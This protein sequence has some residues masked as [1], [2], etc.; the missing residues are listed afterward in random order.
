MAGAAVV[1]LATGCLRRLPPPAPPPAR[2]PVAALHA[3]H[4]E[5]ELL[6]VRHR[7]K[8]GQTLYRIAR[9]YGLTTA[10]LMEANGIDDPRTL[11]VGQELVIPGATEALDVPPTEPA[12]M[13][14]PPPVQGSID[15]PRAADEPPPAAGKKKP[16]KV[17]KVRVVMSPPSTPAAPKEDAAVDEG[18]NAP[19]PRP[20]SNPETAF[21]PELPPRFGPELPP[22]LGPRPPPKSS[23]VA[24]ASAPGSGTPPGPVSTSSAAQAGAKPASKA[25]LEW[26]L[27]GV[28]YARF[29]KK[30]KEAHD[31]IDLAAPAGTEVATAA[32]GT[33]LFAGEQ[34]GYGRIAIVEHAHGLITLYAH[35]RDL[36]VK[37][38]QKV[39]AGQ[40]IATVGESGKTSGP[41]LHF[42]V[43][44]E[45][46]PVD[47]LEH[48][49][50]VPPR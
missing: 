20:A 39:R 27:R 37:T 10:E 38:G 5:P 18:S 48:L 24:K 12:A 15:D 50:P 47:P 33:V 41:H 2:S 17:S 34:Q 11:A 36:R 26:P 43:R 40:V 30:G 7:V 25:P 32:E 23:A 42:E 22:E 6:S 35:N 8:P 4:A 16:P 44:K 31:G 49:G 1:L 46:L 21:G 28:L 45:G 19:K 14:P 29:G 3:E 9:S 13:I